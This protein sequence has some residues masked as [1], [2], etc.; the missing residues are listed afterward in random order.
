METNNKMLKTLIPVIAVV[1][2]FESIMLVSNLEKK[3][4]TSDVIAEKNEI[5]QEVKNE[6]YFD[7]SFVTD[8]KEMKI[9][10]NYQ[11]KLQALVK[12]KKS[13]DAID[14]AIK[15]DSKNLEISGLI[16]DDK[17]EKPIIG[18]VVKEDGMIV[19]KYLIET[20]QGITFNVDDLVN[21]VSFDVKAKTVGLYK[22]EV[23]TGN[24]DKKFVTLFVENTSAKALP[25]ASNQLEINVIK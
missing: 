22:F 8:A 4:V 19:V 12:E 5:I 6:N 21:L 10:K 2:I 16:F 25:F 3:T 23:A 1:V 18:K 17:L 14:I 7:L 11:I 20:K 24:E 13:L 9:G 15:Y